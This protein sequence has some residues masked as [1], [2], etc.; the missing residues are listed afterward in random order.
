MNF[1]S[2]QVRHY[3][4]YAGFF[5]LFFFISSVWAQVPQGEVYGHPLGPETRDAFN[6]TSALLAEKPIV[7]GNFEQE[8]LLSRLGRSLKSSGNFIIAADLGMVWDTQKPFPSTLALGKDYLVQSRPGG[9]KNIL[10]AEGNETFIR[11]AEVISAVFSGNTGRLL[12]NFEVFYLD[13]IR[14]ADNG[15]ASGNNPGWELGLLPRDRAIASFAV[16]I[17]L[18]GDSAIRSI[19]INEQNGDSIEYVL[20]NHSYPSELALN[21]KSFFTVP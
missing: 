14:S 6:A 10:S 19:L 3:Y 9:Q 21:E 5:F 1:R 15:R 2:L 16:K 13:K 8:K 11:L 18:K 12:E 4:I 7:R 20:S 17:T